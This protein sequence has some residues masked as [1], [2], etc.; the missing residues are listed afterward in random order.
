MDR[1]SIFKVAVAALAAVPVLGRKAMA[2]GEKKTHK[3]AVH[4]D[5]NDPAVMRLALAN[6]RN[7][8]DLFALHGEHLEVEIVCYSQGLH[9]LRDDTS[10][11]KDEIKQ[12]RAKVP[13]VTFGACNNTK[14]AMEKTEGKIIPIIPEAHVVSAGIVRLV[15]L[16]EEGYS[17]IK[18]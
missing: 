15:E 5:Q 8:H 3:M 12:T 13:Q 10:P 7:A 14:R 18:P 2:E 6:T 4:V 16:Q 17:Y 11:V 9:M 1:R